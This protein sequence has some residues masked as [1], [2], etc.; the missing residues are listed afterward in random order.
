MAGRDEG[1]TIILD[2]RARERRGGRP[3]PPLPRP[4]AFVPGVPPLCQFCGFETMNP[5]GDDGCC[6]QCA[7]DIEE[8]R[9]PGGE[10]PTE[11]P[12]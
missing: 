4:V 10:E 5:S 2:G 1:F 12:F 8:G 9:P 11:D 3:L 7:D 6:R